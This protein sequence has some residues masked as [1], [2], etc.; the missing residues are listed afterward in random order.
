VSSAEQRYR[1]WL[2]F[3]PKE[4]RRARGE[5]ILATLVESATRD[6]RLSVADLVHITAHGTC[7]RFRL[8]ARR[9]RMGR[10]PRSVYIATLLIA[11]LAALNLMAAAFSRNGPKNQSS[12][13]DNI[14]VG[15]VF[16]GLDLLLWM[17]NRRLYPVAM[18]TLVL[19]T[20]TS[21]VTID[22]FVNAYAVLPLVLLIVGRKR[23]MA[24]I[25]E[26][27]LPQEPRSVA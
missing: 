25:P 22:L 24:A 18:G 6:G 3:Y 19:L 8:A 12:H 27:D 20:A 14:V 15:L 2:R 16:V 26:V 23:Y 9:L 21:V 11:I 10:L 7:V 17:W 13:L 1:R 5:E 4:Y